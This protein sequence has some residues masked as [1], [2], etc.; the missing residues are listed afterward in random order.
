MGIVL[1]DKMTR[2]NL[3]NKTKDFILVLNSNL[4]T[5]KET[6][7]YET[8]VFFE[9][10]DFIDLE[11][12]RINKFEFDKFESFNEQYKKYYETRFLNI[13]STCYLILNMNKQTNISVI[14][15]CLNNLKN[16]IGIDSNYSL[17]EKFRYG[18]SNYV[19]FGKNGAGKTTLLKYLRINLINSNVHFAQAARNVNYSIDNAWYNPFQN[20]LDNVLN[21]VEDNK[22]MLLLS[23]CMLKQERRELEGGIES[24]NTI[25]NK[26]CKMF[27]S[28][29][30]DRNIEINEKDELKLVP[31]GENSY[32][33]S[34]ASDGEKTIAY[35]IM[36][37]LLAA[38]NSF[39]F[40]DEPENHLNGS[41]MI[42]LFDLLE[43]SRQDVKFV[44]STH[45]IN[46]VKSRNNCELVY[47]QKT[48]KL[49]HWEFKTISMINDLP[50][51]V[52]L[53]IEGTNDNVLLC[54]GTTLLMMNNY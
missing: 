26:F 8:K 43:S 12:K 17:F 20:N 36:L 54:E 32:S 2:T 47:L 5:K 51:N 23:L 41:L 15:N 11:I 42:K 21:G 38:K 29:G 37:T 22:A 13:E 49:N 35:F 24:E 6:K 3:L 52:I 46:F 16:A 30:L 50:Y 31:P 40:I 9:T 10:V 53:N 19:L 4:N 18:N 7:P 28:L 48:S 33:F 44:Y 34:N 27:N 1:K 25:L 14:I 45:N 39:I